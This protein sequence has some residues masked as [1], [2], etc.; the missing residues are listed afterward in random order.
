VNYNRKTN[1]PHLPAGLDV[2][3]YHTTQDMFPS[4]PSFISCTGWL[5]EENCYLKSCAQ[6]AVMWWAFYIWLVKTCLSPCYNV[7]VLEK[8]HWVCSGLPS[9][10]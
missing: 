6:N 10:T 9:K 5:G 3:Q 8:L 1:E 4:I 2:I 7:L